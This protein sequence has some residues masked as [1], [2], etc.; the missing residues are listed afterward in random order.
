MAG[1]TD[2]EAAFAYL[3]GHGVDIAFLDIEIGE[4]NGIGLAKKC[5]EICPQVNIIFVTGYSEYTMEAFKLRASG[6]LLKPVR[7]SDLRMEIDNLR[8]PLPVRSSKRVRIQT[9][10]NFEI[11]VD[12]TPLNFSRK[13][14]LEVLAY[15]VDRKGAR[16]SM[17]ELSDVLWEG[18]PYDRSKQNHIHQVIFALMQTLKRAGIQDIATK[19]NGDMAIN[20][21]KIDCDYYE[22]INGN[23]ASMNTFNGEYMSNYSWAEFTLGSLIQRNKQIL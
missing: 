7:A 13:K 23:V 2:P 11:F 14:C 3:A 17:P 4:L 16:V 21:E 9:F 8:N 10:G 15:L 20:P 1:F 5:K 18:G 22:A 6:Y 19:I 12:G